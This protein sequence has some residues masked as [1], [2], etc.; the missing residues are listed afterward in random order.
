MPKLRWG[1]ATTSQ[2]IHRINEVAEQ[3]PNSVV[4]G[5]VLG[6]NTWNVKGI[7]SQV[8]GFLFVGSGVFH[9]IAIARATKKPVWCWNPA[10]Q[11]L[12]ELDKRLVEGYEKRNRAGIAHFL[13]AKSVGVLVSARPGQKNLGRSLDLQA[14]CPN[15]KV[16]VFVC[17]TL[18]INELENWPFIDCWVNTLCP[19]LDDEKLPRFVNIDELKDAGVIDLKTKQSHE[20]PIWMSKRGLT[21]I[22]VK[23]K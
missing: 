10:T 1:I 20:V 9:P 17:D 5:Q 23:A 18:N 16:Y 21:K 6:C 15:K 11:T 8:D 14:A 4:A 2:H 22:A 7:T 19:R 3:L 13:T 12:A